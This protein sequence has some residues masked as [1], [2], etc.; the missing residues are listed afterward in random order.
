MINYRYLK[1]ILCG[2]ISFCAALS[3]CEKQSDSTT[4]QTPDRTVRPYERDSKSSARTIS[5]HERQGQ[6]TDQFAKDLSMEVDFE[7]D[8]TLD[9]IDLYAELSRDYT[10]SDL[11]D[12]AAT[13]VRA[14]PREQWESMLKFIALL[15][16]GSMTDLASGTAQSRLVT[17]HPELWPE[18]VD[19]FKDVFSDTQ[20]ATLTLRYASDLAEVSNPESVLEE[21]LKSQYLDSKLKDKFLFYFASRWSQK[22]SSSATE[23]ILRHLDLVDA[24]R[25][26]SQMGDSADVSQI[27][28]YIP[29]MK[30]SELSA[31][32]RE[33]ISRNLGA[34]FGE[35]GTDIPPSILELFD[36]K[37]QILASKE[38][39]AKMAERDL[40]KVLNAVGKISD[41]E[42]RDSIV[43]RIIPLI[44]DY[45]KQ[46]ASQWILSIRNEKIRADVEGKY[47]K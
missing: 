13:A 20:M 38:Y 25:V 29:R 16:P 7:Y 17:E 40:N 47:S 8:I 43:G 9:P 46:A 26:V 24:L 15:P 45:D 33:S 6:G 1:L 35:N 3:S 22:D 2:F 37:E 34:S 19:T 44:Y 11:G 12:I 28:N 23:A 10:G 32:D 27:G 39:Y 30:D 18:R 31:R 42:M 21:T 5:K 36:K 14:Y 41:D 4:N